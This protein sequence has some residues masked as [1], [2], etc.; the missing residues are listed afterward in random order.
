MARQRRSSRST[1]SGRSGRDD[2]M[3]F[4]R[5]CAARRNGVGSLSAALIAARRA[6][7]ALAERADSVQLILVS[8]VG[9]SEIDSATG[10]LRALWPGAVRI[11]RVALRV[12]TSATWAL[13]RTLGLDDPLGPAMASVR[14]VRGALITR[15]V[16]G[17]LTAADST[18]ARGGGT[19][20]RWDSTSAVRPVAEGLAVG[21]DVVVAALARRAVPPSARVRARWADGSAAATEIPLGQGCLREIGV[22][23]P[24]AGD[25]ALH[26]PFQN[27]ARAARAVRTCRSGARRGLS[28]RCVACRHHTQC[29]ARRCASW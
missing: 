11:E 19:V 13:E 25:I 10:R 23:L 7:A 1:A 24:A 2:N 14:P 26:P 27:I 21:D 22:A 8:P 15:L 17:A 4:A 5:R 9:V 28:D 12:D 20:V 29:S 16:R 3:G 6:S 18:F